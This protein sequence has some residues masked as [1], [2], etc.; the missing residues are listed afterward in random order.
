MTKRIFALATL[1]L[2]AACG[3]S[4]TSTTQTY[5]TLTST[6]SETS[7]LI[8]RGR[9]LSDAVF[10][11]MNLVTADVN[12]SIDHATNAVAIG[13][14]TDSDGFDANG[15]LID[16]TIATTSFATPPEFFGT[17]DFVRTYQLILEFGGSEGFLGIATAPVDMPTTNTATFTGESSGFGPNGE[18]LAAPTTITANFGTNRLGLTANQTVSGVTGSITVTDAVISDN[19]INGGTLT[20]T[21]GGTAVNVTTGG[22]LGDI[23][24]IDGYFYGYDAA[25]GTPDEIGIEIGTFG[26]DGSVDLT[27]LAD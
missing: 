6:A 1:P 24:N 26:A 27:I 21:R 4:V 15:A 7:P 10:A 19:A 8:G 11:G 22:I 3:G 23:T 16:D 2:L 14:I 18:W 12:G 17:Y 25:N 13:T 5:Q 9:G 20:A